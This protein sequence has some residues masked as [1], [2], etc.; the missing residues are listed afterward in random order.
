MTYGAAN[1]IGS[2]GAKALAVALTPN[3]E[4]VCNGSVNTLDLADNEIGSEGAKALAATL[5]PNTVAALNLSLNTLKLN[6]N[7][8]GDKDKS[9]LWE[10]VATHPNAATA[11][12]RRAVTTLPFDFDFF[13]IDEATFFESDFVNPP[14][15]DIENFPEYEEVD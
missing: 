6:G 5:T 4:G 7:Y 11:R 1:Q 3:A 9:A 8:L 10:A 15:S 14:Y 13:G 12:A 2:E